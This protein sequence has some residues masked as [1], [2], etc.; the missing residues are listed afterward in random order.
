[1]GLLLPFVSDLGAVCQEV[2]REG[3]RVGFTVVSPQG[4]DMHCADKFQAGTD[5]MFRFQIRDAQ[6]AP[7]KGLYPAAWLQERLNGEVTGPQSCRHKLQQ[8]LSGGIFS[9]AALDLNVYH[10]LTLN[11]DASVSVV[12]P[13]FSFGGSRLLNMV[14]LPG[15]GYDWVKSK[16]EQA[17]YISIPDQHQLV[18]LDTVRWRLSK[19]LD[20]A[21]QWHHPNHL[22]L[23]PDQHYLWLSVDEG[24]L[25]V[26]RETMT[27]KKQLP[28]ADAKSGVSELVFS[29]NGR[30]LYVAIPDIGTLHV[31]D[32][33]SLNVVKKL[34]LG[35]HPAYLAYSP[36][37]EALYVSHQGD[38]QIIVVDGQRHKIIATIKSDPGL[39]MIRFAP[40]GRL[41]FVV[42]PEKNRLYVIDAA[43]NRIVQSGSVERAPN[44]IYFSDALAY[45]RHRDSATVLMITLD[46]KDLGQ[47]GRPIPVVDA[48]A[49]YQPPGRQTMPTP[50]AG[51]IK[52]PGEDAVLIANPEDKT[53]Y[54]YK[55]GMAAPMGQFVNSG[56]SPRA[57]L[58]IDR[59]LK[60]A[61]QPG[62]YQ[63]IAKLPAK[64]GSYDLVYF[65]DNPRILHCFEMQLVENTEQAPPAYLTGIRRLPLSHA[66]K[67]GHDA[68]LHFALQPTRSLTL[69]AL[70]LLDSGRWQQRLRLHSNG[71]GQVNLSFTPPL[72]GVYRVFLS[73]DEPE[74]EGKRQQF[75]YEVT[76]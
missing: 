47:P 46:H 61:Q 75:M 15:A 7:L 22:A 37:A 54:F 59:S 48:P 65:M 29:A 44:A 31:I 26:E 8:F 25:V 36:L 62:V 49:G 74:L 66:L 28:L 67:V 68:Q 71:Q 63:T 39:G 72:A 30:F 45:I 10:V 2:Q 18:K 27:L 76:P 13:L 64:A 33:V 51:I 43:H 34:P 57:V 17:V 69:Q 50:A 24:L 53:V 14:S 12:D 6:G 32:T 3:I 41:G 21:G 16:D 60:E 23:Q 56:K 4:A 73:S 70:V 11:E 38:G 40:Q 52:A 5:H 58:A 1:M 20:G 42:N 9:Q 35:K 19:A 55:E